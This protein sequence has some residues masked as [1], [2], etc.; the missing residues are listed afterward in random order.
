MH[1]NVLRY[2]FLLLTNLNHT[3]FQ[4]KFE[5]VDFDQTLI[6]LVVI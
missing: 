1:L 2:I 4:R 3:I 6:L 5:N